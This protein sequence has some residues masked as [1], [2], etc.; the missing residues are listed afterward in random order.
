MHSAWAWCCALAHS[1]S[2]AM[3]G[4]PEGQAACRE[5]RSMLSK[6]RR[7]VHRKNVESSTLQCLGPGARE[8]TGGRITGWQVRIEVGARLGRQQ[9]DHDVNKEGQLW[10]HTGCLLLA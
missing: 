8:G 2:G 10:T 1:S 7:N 5:A 4:V 6:Q 3:S 9:Q